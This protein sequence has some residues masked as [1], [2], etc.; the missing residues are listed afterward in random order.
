ME[1]HSVIGGRGGVVAEALASVGGGLKLMS[2][3]AED[4]YI[5]ADEYAELMKKSGLTANA[6]ADRVISE[7]S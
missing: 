5:H 1:E 6:I 3:G 2:I 4:E 7:F